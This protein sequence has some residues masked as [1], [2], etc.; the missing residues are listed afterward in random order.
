MS[1]SVF[2]DT[3]QLKDIVGANTAIAS[4]MVELYKLADRLPAP[5]AETLRAELNKVVTQAEQIQD[6]VSTVI[7]QNR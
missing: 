4:S 7:R 6:S 2:V 1:Q 3:K 5:D